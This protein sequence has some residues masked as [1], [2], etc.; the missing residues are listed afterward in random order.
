MPTAAVSEGLLLTFSHKQRFRS[1]RICF[2]KL[3][4]S[5]EAF[6]IHSLECHTKWAIIHVRYYLWHYINRLYDNLLS[7]TSILNNLKSSYIWSQET[8]VSKIAYS[9]DFQP[10]Q[11]N[12][13]KKF[14]SLLQQTSENWNANT[15]L[16]NLHS[17][18]PN[19]YQRQ[20][21]DI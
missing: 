11:S 5:L 15:S 14:L 6:S 1:H 17:L 7:L 2:R 21:P 10:C 8:A 18:V 4:N 13:L 16:S 3:N 9:V 19:N 20:K 12:Y